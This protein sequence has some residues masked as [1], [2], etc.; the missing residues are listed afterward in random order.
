M[1]EN[2]QIANI[3]RVIDKL[4]NMPDPKDKEIRFSP[5]QEQVEDQRERAIEID[6]KKGGG[7]SIFQRMQSDADQREPNKNGQNR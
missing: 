2:E 4:E 3:K 7:E 1:S 5:S 6:Y